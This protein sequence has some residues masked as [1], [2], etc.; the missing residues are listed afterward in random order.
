MIWEGKDEGGN[1]RPEAQRS[2]VQPYRSG[3]H[4]LVPT[5]VPSPSHAGSTLAPA[6]RAWPEGLQL[7]WTGGERAERREG[8]GGRGEFE[9]I[10]EETHP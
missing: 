8:V 10:R 7:P 3:P 1:S 5:G 6:T 4:E 2:E 9:L